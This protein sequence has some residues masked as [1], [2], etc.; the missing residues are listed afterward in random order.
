MTLITGVKG[1]D[2]VVIGADR[3]VLR[4][5]EIEYADKIFEFDI[6]GKVLFAA[7]GLT[8]IRDD[9]L[10]L[11]KSEIS[12]RK[13]V[14]TLYEVK[15]VVEDIIADLTERYKDRVETNSPIGVLMSGL[16]K[17]SEGK[18]IL[19]Y[20]HSQGYG[21][22]SSF[23]CSGHGGPYAYSL[24]KFLCEPHLV[25]DLSVNEVA[26][27]LAFVIAWVAND[28]DTTVGG[29]PQVAIVKDESPKVEYLP[30]KIIKEIEEDVKRSKQT[31]AK[32]LGLE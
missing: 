5:G 11:L 16:E 25:P 9:F 26:R 1:E 7:E 21:E 4:G 10:L 24:A 2:G 31:L 20:I 28:V 14:D 29:T 6:G 12:R 22:Q 27:R 30:D 19:Y 18:A 17:I 23:L 13:G 15:M 3:K 8:G 32:L